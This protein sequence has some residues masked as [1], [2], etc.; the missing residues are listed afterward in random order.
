MHQFDDDTQVTQLDERRWSAEISPAWSIGTNP[1]GGYVL[2][3][4]LAAVAEA[5]DHPHPLST[6]AHYLKPAATG[7]AE[8][9][10]DVHKRGRRQ[11]VLSA[12]LVQDGVERVRVLTS[13]GDL[14]AFA[15]P[16][17]VTAT[18]PDL[19][20]P[21]ECVGRPPAVIDTLPEI[22][23]RF[24]IL[25]P[26]G[27]P[28][29]AWPAGAASEAV[30]EGWIRFTGGREPDVAALPLLADAFPPPAL[31]VAAASWI[32]T[33]ELT[34][35]T[36][37]IPAPGWLRAR[38]VTRAMVDGLLEE[39]GELWDSENRLV[40]MSRQLALVLPPA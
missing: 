12:A 9:H 2:A 1:N 14:E 25:S 15:G 13:C 17:M 3:V 6:T 34:V 24:E 7:P 21:A 38:F 35:H 16:T 39:D 23:R 26:E 19:P 22:A 40:A 33:L 37:G 5:V 10:V 18:P 11:S 30:L 20:P 4:V 29:V 27:S 31:L 32:P 8:I 36:R 28:M